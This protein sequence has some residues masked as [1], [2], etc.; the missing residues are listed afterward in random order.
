MSKKRIL[1]VDDEEDLVKT[2]AFR[3]EANGYEVTSAYNGMEAIDKVHKDNPDLVILDIMLPKIDGYKVCGL[4]KKDP[5]YKD[6]PIIMFSARAQESDIK[7]GEEAGA[8]AYITKPFEPQ[9][10]LEKIRELLK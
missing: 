2:V 4:L 3:L 5:R 7:M 6:I 10:L 9:A 1:L 8:D